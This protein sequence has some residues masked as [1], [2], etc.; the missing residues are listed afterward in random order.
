MGSQNGYEESSYGYQVPYGEYGKPHW[1]VDPQMPLAADKGPYGAAIE[2][3]TGEHPGSPT[4]TAADSPDV[5]R[6]ASAAAASLSM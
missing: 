1:D 5:S 2:G 4:V 6:Y 3:G